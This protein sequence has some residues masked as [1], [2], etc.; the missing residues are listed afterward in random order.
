MFYALSN[1][2]QLGSHVSSWRYRS[3]NRLSWQP[4]WT[5][6]DTGGSSHSQVKIRGDPWKGAHG[7]NMWIWFAYNQWEKN[8]GDPQVCSLTINIRGG[9][10]RVQGIGDRVC[11]D[12]Y[13]PSFRPLKWELLFYASHQL[14]SSCMPANCHALGTSLSPVGV[15]LRPGDWKLQCHTSSH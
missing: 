6:P 7:Y 3:E 9:F 8:R 4:C 13:W 11:S 2:K 10:V 14:A 12:K 5:L 1:V 15:S